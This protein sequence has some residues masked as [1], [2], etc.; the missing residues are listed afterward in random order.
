M[1]ML[2]DQ[3]A[4]LRQQT[5]SLA[6]QL[7]KQRRPTGDLETAANAVWLLER[8][9]EDI[10]LDLRGRGQFA[11]QTLHARSPNVGTYELVKHSHRLSPLRDACALILEVVDN[12]PFTAREIADEA[13]LNLSTVRNA[14][15]KLRC[16]GRI[17]SIDKKNRQPA[18]V[19]FPNFPS[20]EVAGS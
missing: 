20:R 3:Q 13:D 18:Y 17:T 11:N 14:L 5:E 8:N 4:K 9:G 10:R 19:K 16:E 12:V 1:R 15:T 7:R 2:A 6:L